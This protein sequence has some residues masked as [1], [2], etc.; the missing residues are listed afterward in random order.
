MN[1]DIHELPPPSNPDVFESLCLDLW[2]DVWQDAEAKKNGRRGQNQDGVDIFGR[3]SGKWI[4]VQCKQKNGLLRTRLTSKELE[5]EVK[6]ACNFKPALHQFILATSGPRDGI[7]QER[8]RQLTDEHHSKGL[9]AVD[10]WSWQEIWPEFCRRPELFN[11]VGAQYWPYSFQKTFSSLH[12]L[13]PLPTLFGRDEQL[14]ELEKQLTTS[15]KWLGL[16]GMG[17]VGKTA[18]ATALAHRLKIQCPDAQLHFDLRGA[19]IQNRP[20]AK[21]TEAM[22]FVIRSIHPEASFPENF[23]ELTAL[24]RSIL[25]DA[26]RVLLVFDNVADEAQIQSLLPPPNCLL[27]VTSRKKF[28][29]P[30]FA[31]QNVDCLKPV[32][33]QELLVKLAS[34]IKGC[35]NEAAELCGHLPLA[36]LVVAGIFNHHSIIEPGRLLDDL[37]NRRKKLDAVDAAFQVSYELLSG[38]LR[39]R[40]CLLSVFP[41]SFDFWAATAIWGK[42][43]PDDE[44]GLKVQVA[45]RAETEPDL[46]ALVNASLIEWNGSARRFHLHNLVR[47]FCDEKLSTQ[48]RIQSHYC[49][50]AHFCD[51][52]RE[53]DKLYS[54]GGGNVMRGLAMFNAELSNISYGYRWVFD[55][56]CN[57]SFP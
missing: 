45:L 18:L 5:D 2:K 24:Y 11:R 55:S 3:N 4:G 54:G 40:W 51:V 30:G 52:L 12:Q 56:F 47:K 10:I 16:Q 37:R 28:T 6:D 15:S 21:S 20:L 42:V 57:A 53:A 38:E 7:V 13:L 9:F 43:S 19:D 44:A 14:T 27:I 49:H 29:A 41:A 1:P 34:R 26:G 17:G 35:E 31:M 33:S 22:Q 23:D 48:E 32:K 25:G 50:S 46:Q 8:A 39:L 36:L